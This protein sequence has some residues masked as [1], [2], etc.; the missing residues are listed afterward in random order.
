MYWSTRKTVHIAGSRDGVAQLCG[1]LKC[2]NLNYEHYWK[3]TFWKK[4]YSSGFLL[5][6]PIYTCKKCN[7]AAMHKLHIHPPKKV[8]YNRISRFHSTNLNEL[9]A[10]NYLFYILWETIVFIQLYMTTLRFYIDPVQSAN[11]CNRTTFGCV[12]Y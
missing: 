12:F 5:S 11:Y 9:H 8:K 6:V 1:S 3:K 10:L 4:L 2:F 7:L